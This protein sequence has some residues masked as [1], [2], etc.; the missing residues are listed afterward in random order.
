MSGYSINIDE[1]YLAPSLSFKI[2]NTYYNKKK[3][4]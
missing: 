3:L 1:V 2:F 4:K